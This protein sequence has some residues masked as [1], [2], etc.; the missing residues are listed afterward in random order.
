MA[1]ALATVLDESNPNKIPSALQSAK[2]GAAMR[3]T[4]AFREGTVAAHTLTLPETAK[5]G[6]VMRAFA[7]T[8]A[9]PGYKTETA[10]ETAAPGVGLCAVTPTG[11]ILFNAAD[12]VT[13]A[14][15]VYE[16]LEGEVLQDT[17][18]VTASVATLAQSRRAVILLSVNV[19]AG[20]VLGLKTVN[21]RGTAAPAA[22][23]AAL[24]NAGNTVVF[25]A[26]DVVT[27][28]A[29][30]RYIAVPGAG[31]GSTA[32]LSNRLAGNVDM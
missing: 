32:S 10:P 8:G 1:R 4:P 20:L 17:V 19:T 21:A 5:A 27:G 15:V 28:T 7:R 6:H 30:V 26:A 12:A 31:N 22:T 25:N 13:A 24:S 14:E 23:N 18:P 11:N 3:L 16:P 29:T 2:A 9:A